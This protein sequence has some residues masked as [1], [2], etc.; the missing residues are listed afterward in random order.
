MTFALFFQ[1]LIIATYFRKEINNTFNKG[2]GYF[3][4]IS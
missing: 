4:N 2:Q 1:Q 3:R